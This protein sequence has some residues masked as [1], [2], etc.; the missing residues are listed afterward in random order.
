MAEDKMVGGHHPLNGD[1]FEQALGDGEGQ[2]NLVGCS[3]WG[4]KGSDM[5]EYYGAIKR[6]WLLTCDVMDEYQN[7]CAEQKNSSTKEICT[8]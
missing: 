3:P 2:G 4:Y 5:T 6:N 1:E 7:H 8:A